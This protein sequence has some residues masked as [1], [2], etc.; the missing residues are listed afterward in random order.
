MVTIRRTHPELA[1]TKLKTTA[2]KNNP[3]SLLLLD[4]IEKSSSDIYNLFLTLLDEG[5]M[6]DAFGKKIGGRH[7]FVIGTSNAGAEYIRQLVQKGI[8]GTDLQSQVM[9]H[10]LQKGIFSPEFIN[11]F[12]GVVV[13][14]PLGK[15]ELVKI[16]KLML[17]DLANVLK[18]KGI[19]LVAGEETAIKL[20]EDGYNPAFGARPMRR[21][22]DLNFGDLIGKA[23]LSDEIQDGDKVKIVPG[24]AKME[25]KIEKV[26]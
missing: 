25:Y 18:K 24:N 16:A 19:Y 13:Y 11:R 4:E 15:E 12:D 2:V 22:V 21:I 20:A 10:V 17:L 7:L 5:S 26:Q 14:E 8:K 9:E 23:L 3:A 6:T 1:S